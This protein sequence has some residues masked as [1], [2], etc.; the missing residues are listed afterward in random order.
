MRED[1]SMT[2]KRL[3]ALLLAVLMLMQLLPLQALTEEKAG[4][5]VVSSNTV[6]GADYATV[7]FL[8]PDGT[9]AGTPVQIALG[10]ALGVLPA[11]PEKEGCTFL[12]WRNENGVLAAEDQLVEDDLA[13]IA[14]YYN[15]AYPALKAE[16]SDDHLSVLIQA[17]EGA[18]PA[19]VMAVLQAASLSEDQLSAI[20]TAMHGGVGDVSAID[21]SFLAMPGRKKVQPLVPVTVKVALHDQ[22]TDPVS[23]I[24]L[25]DDGQ[26]EVV[27]SGIEEQEFTFEAKSFSIY[28][29]ADESG[30]TVTARRTYKFEDI[31][32]NGTYKDY[33]FYNK[34]G[35][36]VST[37]ITK[38]GD[39][40]EEI[41]T[42]YH[43]GFTFQGW[44]IWDGSSWGDKVDFTAAEGDV[45]DGEEVTVRAKYDNVYYVNFHEYEKDA[46]TDVI[47]T[48]KIVPQGQQLLISDVLA[49]QPDDTHIFYGWKLD[50]QAYPVYEGNQLKEAKINITKNAELYPYFVEAYW[51][52]FVSGETGSQASYVPAQFVQANET[53][54]TLPVPTREGYTFD[55]WYT[56]SIA[57]NVITYGTQVSDGTG[58]VTN[59]AAGLKLT[60]ETTLF[61]HWTAQDNA[62]YSVVIWKQ[63][64]SDDKNAADSA[65][66]YDYETSYTRTGVTGAAVSP[67]S[68]DLGHSWTGFHYART[69]QTSET[70]QANGSTVINVY[71]DRDLMAVNFYYQSGD[72]PDGTETAYTYTRTTNDNGTQY[73]VLED[74]TYVQL[75]RDSGTTT[76][77][78]Y[79]TY[80]NYWWYEYTGT[81]YTRSGNWSNYRYTATQ[82]NGN[83]LPPNNDDTQYYTQNGNALTRRTETTTSYEWT[84]NGQPYTGTRYTRST[85]SGY[86]HMV[87]WTGLYG[88]SFSKYDYTWPSN[89]KWNESSEGGGTNQTFLSGFTQTENPYNLYDQGNT[90]STK[91]YH[92]KQA[93]DGKYYETEGTYRYTVNGNGGQFNFS[94]KFD[95]FTV[96]SYNTG[97]S[98]FN[99]NGGANTNMSD[100]PNTYPLHVYHTRNKWRID[101]MSPD[102]GGTFQTVHTTSN[103]SI[104]FEAPLIGYDLTLAQVGLSERPHY[105]FTGW[106][107]DETCTTKFDFSSTMPN[108]N[109]AVYAGWE[110]V[111]YQVIVDPDGG[112]LPQAVGS[113]YM[114]K[115]YQDTISRYEIGRTYIEDPN[116]AYK[117]VYVDG[118]NDPDGNIKVR[119]ATYELAEDGYTGT[120]YRPITSADPTYSLV[121]WYVVDA[122]GKTT[123]TPYDFNAEIEGP[124]TIR[125]VWRLAGDYGVVYNA[126]A[127]VDGVTVSG[128]FTQDSPNARY[129]DGAEVVV[130]AGPTGVTQYVFDGWEVVDASGNTLDNNGGNYYQPGE[131]LILKAGA[132]ADSSKIIHIQA[133]Y[134]KVEESDDPVSVTKIIYDANG[135]TTS[136]TSSADENGIPLITVNAEK[137][138][139]AVTKLHINQEQTTYGQSDFSRGSNEGWVLMGWNHDKAKADA[140]EVEFKCGQKIGADNLDP[141]DN[142]LYAVWQQFGILRIVKHFDTQPNNAQLIK[143]SAANLKITIKNEKNETITSVSGPDGKP[144][145][146]P[147]TLADF[148]ADGDWTYI[149]KHE[150]IPA[151]AYTVTESEEKDMLTGYDLVDDASDSGDYINTATV[152]VTHSGAEQNTYTAQLENH[153][154]GKAKLNVKK[155]VTVSDNNVSVPTN[156]EYSFTVTTE[157]GKLYAQGDGTWKTD[158]KVF[159]VK[160]DGSFTGILGIVPGQ[161]YRITELGTAPNE[162][163]TLGYAQI[164]GYTLTVTYKGQSTGLITAD[165]GNETQV[166]IE[167]RYEPIKGTVKVEKKAV[168]QAGNA[169]L[170]EAAFAFDVKKSDGTTLTT[171]S[172][173]K[174]GETGKTSEN[175]VPYGAY[176]VEEH[177]PGATLTTTDGKTTYRFDSTEYKVGE[178]EGNEVSIQNQGDAPIVTVTNKYTQL[179]D[180]TVTKT[181]TG[182]AAEDVEKLTNFQIA[183]TIKETGKADVTSTSVLTLTSGTKSDTGLTYTWTIPNVPVGASVVATESGYDVTEYKTK[184]ATETQTLASVAADAT[185]NKIEFT[186]EYELGSLTITKTFEGGI[187]DTQKN[188]VTF[189]VTGPNDYSTTFTYAQ[190]ES[191]SK[192]LTGLKLGEYAIAES[193]NTFDGYKL[194]VTI[195]KEA[196]TTGQKSVVL[197]AT[198]DE[199][200]KKTVNFTNKYEQG[201]LTIKKTATGLNGEDAV[202]DSASFQIKQGDKDYGEPFTYGA[203]KSAADG[204]KTY[205]VTVPYGYSYT[206]TESGADVTGYSLATTYGPEV[207]VTGD[208][209]SGELK[210]ENTYAQGSLKIIKQWSGDDIGDTA[211]KSLSITITGKDVNPSGE[212]K[213]SLTIS[214]AAFENGEYTIDHLPAGEKYT[215]EETNAGELSTYYTFNTDKS[216]TKVEGVTV[217]TGDTPAKASLKNDYSVKTQNITVKKVW[218]DAD[219]QDGKRLN[220]TDFGGY[221]SLK[222]GEEP[223]NGVT[224]TITDGENANEWTITYTNLPAAENGVEITYS[225]METNVPSYTTAYANTGDNAEEKNK[226]LNNGTITNTHTPETVKVVLTKAWSDNDDSSFR[227]IP[228][229]FKAL[230]HLYGGDKE[231]TSP[232]PQ[233]A[234]VEGNAD[235]YTVTWSNLPKYSG[236]KVINY[237][238]SE[239][240]ITKVTD[241]VTY[242]LYDSDVKND[243][244]AAAEGKD[245]EYAAAITN[246][247]KM[248]QVYLGKQVTGNMGDRRATF[249]FTVTVKDANE[250][251]ITSTF[252]VSKNSEGKITRQHGSPALLGTFPVG[253]TVTIT[254]TGAEDYNKTTVGKKDNE[255]NAA[256]Q[257]NVSAENANTQAKSITFTVSDKGNTVTFYNDKDVKVDTG[258]PLESKPYLMMLALIPVAGLMVMLGARR[259][260]RAGE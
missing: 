102:A 11:A 7:T 118:K 208:T 141:G 252:T 156:R 235:H 74:G 216:T 127:M 126:T 92:Y 215:V 223:V 221:L 101:Y 63:K 131:D 206:V 41:P 176:T 96:N 179:V 88:Q 166:Q 89:Y 255:E 140:G 62:T 4:F 193:E 132:W 260:R 233:A 198:S 120:R 93:L 245:N 195:D 248:A 32:S 167:N 173:V 225:V 204:S 18:L 81:F 14:S 95:G 187:S 104:Y 259:R 64:V 57:D 30:E 111:W 47:L 227:P 241:G 220:R 78:V 2:K 169:I 53:V 178:K 134:T 243:K 80:G 133:H 250:K 66:T 201:E 242:Q 168:D 83:N 210:V 180:V 97:E 36:Y 240:A 6:E 60:E 52:R 115:Q 108:A 75:T 105:T 107:A 87:T 23:V 172:N 183:Y 160:N 191:G 119:T 205:T 253:A 8:M 59:P 12:G 125:A 237:S 214:Y 186:N 68:A 170:P 165:G 114:W 229:V 147:T 122:S 29:I 35:E 177:T 22:P 13:L 189:T 76:T 31:D 16:Y 258:V 123:S 17:P 69:V 218:D 224:P 40:L 70:I 217:V 58:K 137:T 38:K 100:K 211:K 199:T 231:V 257:T 90:G 109:V 219:N 190:M 43:A 112:E 117:Y 209:L 256:S 185:Q 49:P 3:A 174:P 222:N 202:P 9:P 203:M 136:V 142:T 27:V 55:G 121:G 46:E 145:S 249:E 21:I 25:T 34:N 150:N 106:Y 155:Q 135:G 144:I 5:S 232:A 98:G 212:N 85:M 238:I 230:V 65:K 254:E 148:E 61:G 37:Q 10:E 188:G 124:V 116:G 163:G 130:Q 226:A 110:P 45:T 77:R 19:D 228:E 171:V 91:I 182:I 149:W 82:Y 161:K 48:T 72:Q 158:E 153:Y 129:S 73:G 128:A 197:A 44:Y 51:L 151:G 164:E 246:T 162:D 15:Y 50:D 54:T 247:R 192:T 152:T 143:D 84:Y 103:Q 196:S 251:D 39:V 20:D 194:T 157:D 86:P 239:D 33:N 234:V 28:A 56:G 99:A 79:Y 94:D 236:G 244:I 42:P 1:T 154:R 24:N 138:Q 175:S 159:T 184:S 26:A 139:V 146:L 67:S 213:D 207:S 113:T 181:F 71:Y 200:M